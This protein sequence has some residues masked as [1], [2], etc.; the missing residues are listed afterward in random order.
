MKAKFRSVL[1]TGWAAFA[2]GP[3]GW[4]AA[5]ISLGT[6]LVL[7]GM[8]IYFALHT[9]APLARM[10][11]AVRVWIKL[12]DV[13]QLTLGVWLGYRTV[14]AIPEIVQAFTALRAE[15]RKEKGGAT[16]EAGNA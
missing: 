10:E 13:Y 3:P 8:L 6:V 2:V 4:I 12:A 16:E 7:G 1:L 9:E 11:L 5:W 15:G 14:R